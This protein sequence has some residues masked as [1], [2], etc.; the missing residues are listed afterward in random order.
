MPSPLS[1]PRLLVAPR[2]SLRSHSSRLAFS[3][4]RPRLR[5]RAGSRAVRSVARCMLAVA[6]F[7]LL[8]VNA[9]HFF[10]APRRRPCVL[11]PTASPACRGCSASSP[12]RVFA[13]LPRC[14][15]RYA[16]GSL[17]S[18]LRASRCRPRPA[19]PAVPCRPLTGALRVRARFAPR[20]ALAH[21]VRSGG[22]VPRPP[23]TL[24]LNL[25]T[26]FHALCYFD[27]LVHQLTHISLLQLHCC[28]LAS[29]SL[30]QANKYVCTV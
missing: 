1:L 27:E 4:S 30:Y 3:V 22:C 24:S 21:F 25:Y 15:G 17:R 12:A 20:G 19:P 23:R 26:L 13:T 2:R 7:L 18:P 14:R 5:L 16:P 9:Q 6:P 29:L 11:R 28:D 8:C 10:V